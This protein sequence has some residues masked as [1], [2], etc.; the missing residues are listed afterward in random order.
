MA[1]H[2][3]L[4]LSL[5][6]CESLLIV[7]NVVWWFFE[8]KVGRLLLCWGLRLHLIHLLLGDKLRLIV[9]LGRV[10]RHQLLSLVVPRPILF[11]P[12]INLSRCVRSRRSTN[13]QI[14]SILLRLLSLRYGI[15]ILTLHLR[16]TTDRWS[17]DHRVSLEVRC[18][19][20]LMIDIRLAVLA[21]FLL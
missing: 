10:L 7:R 9:K 13:I 14:L 19:F 3:L 12:P 5:L 15:N 20:P 4:V 6:D 18:H 2:C 11:L 16:S 8:Y 21:S 17:T 1:W